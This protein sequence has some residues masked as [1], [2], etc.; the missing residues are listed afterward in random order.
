MCLAKQN[1][2]DYHIQ[3]FTTALSNGG[4]AGSY[5]LYS[6]IFI[7]LK[8]LRPAKNEEV[9]QATGQG[10][11]NFDSGRVTWEPVCQNSGLLRKGCVWGEVCTCVCVWACV[12]AIGQ[13]CVCPVILSL[14]LEFSDSVVWVEQDPGICLCHSPQHRDYRCTLAHSGFM[15]HSPHDGTENSLPTSLV[16]DFN[17]ALSLRHSEKKKSLYQEVGPIRPFHGWNS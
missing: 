17:K 16:D 9:P 5:L 4:C 10:Y 12:E 13:C 1:L 3:S 14:K 2:R 11:W 8:R 15:G 6:L 7:S